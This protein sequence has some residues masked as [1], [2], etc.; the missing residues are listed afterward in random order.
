MA[1]A[2]VAIDAI[3]RQCPRNLAGVFLAAVAGLLIVRTAVTY[4][5]WDRLLFTPHA[6]GGAFTSLS[7]IAV[8]AFVRTTGLLFDREH[9]LLAYA[10]IYILMAPGLIVMWRR[11]GRL[12]RNLAFVVAGYLVPVVLSV[13]NVHG[14]SGGWSPAARFLVPVAA[15]FWFAAHEYARQ[16]VRVLVAALVVTQVAIN[17]AMWNNPRLLW[18]DGDGLTAFAAVNWF[19]SWP[20]GTAWVWF[21]CAA[22][23][24]L[25]GGLWLAGRP[26]DSLS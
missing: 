13:T 3:R 2:I 10:P 19:P 1:A 26:R 20:G 9:G 17:A 25:A 8:E 11:G 22:T 6:T 18:N 15:L 23:S 16:G 24:L 7:A 14:W 21:A 5:L 4:A 12:G